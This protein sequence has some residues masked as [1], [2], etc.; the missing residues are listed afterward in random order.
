MSKVLVFLYSILFQWMVL[1]SAHA[2]VP[3][4]PHEELVPFPEHQ[5]AAKIVTH[6]LYNY[7]YTKTPLDNELSKTILEQ[8]LDMLD[9]QKLHFVSTDI[10]RFEMHTDKI[11]DYLKKS[12]VE[13]LFSIFKKFRQRLEERVE[14]SLE[15]LE[16]DF[17][18]AIEES[19]ILDRDDSDWANN[20]AE[21][22]E[23]WKRRVKNDF[24]SLKLAGKD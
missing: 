17:N 12:N 1:S 21:L 2:V 6:V 9:P 18:F 4:V 5:R 15:E 13:P 16:N 20:I 10:K 11:D 22:K 24:L 19:I 3:L 14:Y 23:V 7:H 8:Y